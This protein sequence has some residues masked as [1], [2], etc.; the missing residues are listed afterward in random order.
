MSDVRLN[1]KPYLSNSGQPPW[2]QAL[3]TGLLR[4]SVRPNSLFASSPCCTWVPRN[5]MIISPLAAQHHMLVSWGRRATFCDPMLSGGLQQPSIT[6]IRETSS[7][8]RPTLR[9]GL[10][11][12]EPSLSDSDFKTGA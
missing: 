6:M 11:S 10:S 4:Q 8:Q 1:E 12:I 3:G 2:T 7:A 5:S 9:R